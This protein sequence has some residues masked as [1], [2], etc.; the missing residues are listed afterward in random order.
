MFKVGKLVR[1]NVSGVVGVVI[2]ANKDT[3]TVMIESRHG[4]G[5]VCSPFPQGYGLISL[6]GNN[7]RSKK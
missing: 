5:L 7:Y 3:F 4:R 6:I 1:S 2:L